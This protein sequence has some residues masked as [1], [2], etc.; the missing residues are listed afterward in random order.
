MIIITTT[1]TII[2]LLL[3]II[4]IIIVIIIIIFS[5]PPVWGCRLP[6]GSH[7][8]EYLARLSQPCLQHSLANVIIILIIITTIIIIIIITTIIII[9]MVMPSAAGRPPLNIPSS[10]DPSVSKLTA[11]APLLFAVYFYKKYFHG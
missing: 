7:L 6:F 8:S 11:A 10:F 2:V 4:I 9:I 3:L 1:T 5:W